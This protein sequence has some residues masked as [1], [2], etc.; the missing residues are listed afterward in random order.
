[1]NSSNNQNNEKLIKIPDNH[2]HHTTDNK[3]LREFTVVIPKDT[4]LFRMVDNYR[5]DF[6][7]VKLNN[8]LCIPYNYNV[9]FYFDPYTFDFIPHWFDNY[10]EIEIYATNQ[11]ILIFN[12]LSKSYNRGTR[13]FENA[14]IEKCDL[15]KEACGNGRDYDPCFKKEFIK[16]NPDIYGYITMGKS[17]SKVFMDNL[18]KADKN[19]TKNVHIVKSFKGYKGTPEVALYPLMNRST[20][21]ILINNNNE[22]QDKFFNSNKYIYR[23]ITT[24]RRESKTIDEFMK[25]HSTNGKYGFFF[26]YKN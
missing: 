19:K 11:D 1:M 22:D 23:H 16:N 18:K 3:K 4:L 21:N 2:I 6:L 17:D 12:L 20:K 7:G 26:N 10:K 14:V 15:N 13:Y 9:F 8:N 24:L 25:K 5:D